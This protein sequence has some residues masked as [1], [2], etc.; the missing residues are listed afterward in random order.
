MSSTAERC[1]DHPRLLALIEFA[2]REGWD[3]LRTPAG[4]LKLVKSGLP[5]IFKRSTA[6]DLRASQST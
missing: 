2:L 1:R 6:R 4:Q 3:V 5:P